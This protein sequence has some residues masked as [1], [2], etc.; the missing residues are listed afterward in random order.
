VAIHCQDD[1]FDSPLLIE[2]VT[3]NVLDTTTGTLRRI[4]VGSDAARGVRADAMTSDWAPAAPR[5]LVYID[6]TAAAGS[7]LQHVYAWSVVDVSTGAVKEL[8]TLDPEGGQYF[9]AA[10]S[11]DGSQVAVLGRRSGEQSLAAYVIDVDDAEVHRLDLIDVPFNSFG[12]GPAW[13]ADGR[14]LFVTR[15]IQSSPDAFTYQ[16]LRVDVGG[17]ALEVLVDGLV[18]L[19]DVRWSPDRRWFLLKTFATQDRTIVA[20]SLY[21]ADGTL[22]RTFSSDP[23]RSVEDVTWAPSSQRLV[24]AVNRV[25]FG[26]EALIADLDGTE[27]VVAT[28]PSAFAHRIAV[29]P[30]GDLLAL[31]LDTQIVVF[32]TQGNVQAEFDG[33]L[34]GWRPR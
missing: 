22:V 34:Q 31:Q 17:G 28:R 4:E 18:D 9:E 19:P 24:L 32:D 27:L 7:D 26:V 20:R 25:N 6:R 1:N 23:A 11:P 33:T 15:Q 2:T 13:S 12:G 21:R 14:S 3:L 30:D 16:L 29:A 10:W 5:L 8:L